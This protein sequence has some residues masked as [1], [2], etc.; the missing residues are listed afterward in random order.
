MLLS[1]I[2]DDLVWMLPFFLVVL[3]YITG[4]LVQ[5]L[6]Q[7]KKGIAIK[8]LSGFVILLCLFHLTSLP[9]MYNEWPFTTLYSLFLCELISVIIAYCIVSLVKR[10]IP[11]MDD[12][13]GL[14]E[15]IS[16]IAKRNWWHF[17]VWAAVLV[18]IVW[19]VAG[20]ILHIA[21][22]V[23]DTF[24]VSE[25]VTILSRNR[26]MSVLP[27][28]GIEGSVFPATYILVSWE[29]FLAALSK[30][31]LVS[32]AVL[33]HSL[34]PALLIPMHYLAYYAAGR[35]IV[36]KNSSIFLLF[37]LFL[38]LTCGPSTYD[39]G[40]F[41]TLR[42]WQGKSVLVNIMLPLMLYLF[43]KITKESVSLSSSSDQH[44]KGGKASVLKIHDI[45]FLFA[46]LLASQAATT[47]GTYLAPVLYGVYMLTFLI[48]S[49]RWKIFFK[50][51][52]PVAAIVPFVLWKIWILLSA[53]TLGD[54]SEGTGVNERSFTE[55]S[56]RYFGFSLVPILF[57]L[58]IIILALRLKKGRVKPLRFFF[59][60]AS[61]LLIVFFINPV[62]MPFAEHYITGT[63]VYWRLFWL[64]QI[65]F[66]IA[67]AFTVLCGIP[68]L[69]LSKVSLVLF[70]SVTFILSGR[71]IFLDEDYKAS[72]SN[73]AKISETTRQIAYAVRNEIAFDEPQ[74]TEEEIRK[75]EQDMILLLPKTLSKELRQYEDIAV[76][77]YPYYSNNYYAYQTDEEFE[78]LQGLYNTL[79]R[80][81][82]W[83]ADDLNSA[84]SLL[85][86]DYVAIGTQ[87]PKANEEQIPFSFEPVYSGDR[88]TLYKTNAAR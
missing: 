65:T 56:M 62:V 75:K 9:F 44:E 13:E 66:V 42:I 50:L 82:I 84:V 79:Y 1:F 87:T 46:I 32:P 15:A 70:L 58:A 48:I 73:H 36:P 21:P 59:L 12:L 72:F 16:Q 88:Y 41:L 67:A 33:C 64:L 29:A 20:V 52:I 69:T 68:K 34:L 17:L 49:H 63:G 4:D 7:V 10:R 74:L 3:F 39:Q 37:V 24:Y 83:T 2:W 60:I 86:I 45:F 6:F 27:S 54:L 11:L 26:L 30:L 22:N 43:L 35:E 19:Q 5:M 61:G 28:C 85:G 78:I 8:V 47:V 81:K 53:G 51:L 14:R 57:I 18:L 80:K 76:M 77:Y 25:S 31:F 55:L 40:A 23:D 38:N 71:N